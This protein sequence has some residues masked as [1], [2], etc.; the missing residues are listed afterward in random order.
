MEAPLDAEE[1]ISIEFE[2]PEA[3]QTEPEPVSP[4]SEAPQPN[5]PNLTGCR[6]PATKR[7]EPDHE[8]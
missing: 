8:T 4:E 7:T 5:E 6:W 1:F 3:E 2:T